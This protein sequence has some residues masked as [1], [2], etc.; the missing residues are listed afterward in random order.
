VQ[1]ISSGHK[2]Y[3]PDE[4]DKT[5]VK[6]GKNGFIKLY[7]TKEFDKDTTYGSGGPEKGGKAHCGP[8]IQYYI[9]LDIPCDEDTT[10][11]DFPHWDTL[12]EEYK[13]VIPQD[14]KDYVGTCDN[15][16]CST[17][18]VATKCQPR[19]NI[20]DGILVQYAEDPKTKQKTFV[21]C[22]FYVRIGLRCGCGVPEPK[23]VPS[24]TGH[25]DK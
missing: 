20:T 10:A 11:S 14:A 23:P 21:S 16:N 24:K 12:K 2:K 1:R 6:A 15:S 3:L 22:V 8:V 19:T 25:G 4:F 7:E 5:K 9:I 13:A 17:N 18:K